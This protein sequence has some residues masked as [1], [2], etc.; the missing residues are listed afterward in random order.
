MHHSQGLFPELECPRDP[1]PEML[2]LLL[3]DAAEWRHQQRQERKGPS[4][5]EFRV[6][7]E[8]EE[9]LVTLPG[10]SHAVKNTAN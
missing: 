9:L 1:L 3:D 5:D 7:V 2:Q 8:G 6:E 4:S 10:A